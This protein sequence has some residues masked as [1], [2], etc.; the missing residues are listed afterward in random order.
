MDAIPFLQASDTRLQIQLDVH[1]KAGKI[2][3]HA[4]SKPMLKTVVP[5]L[6]HCANNE[7]GIVEYNG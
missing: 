7:L 6:V 3:A 4:L 1:H 5:I 2:I